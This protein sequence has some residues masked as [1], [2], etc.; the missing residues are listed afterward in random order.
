MKSLYHIHNSTNFFPGCTEGS[1]QA[2][3]T[4]ESSSWRSIN[5]PNHVACRHLPWQ[6]RSPLELPS[7]ANYNDRNQDTNL[8]TELLTYRH[9]ILQITPSILT[10]ASQDHPL[11][12]DSLK[13]R[14]VEVPAWPCSHFPT[15]TSAPFLPKSSAVAPPSPLEG[16]SS[17]CSSISKVF[18]DC[19][20][21]CSFW[22][23]FSST[24]YSLL[25]WGHDRCCISCLQKWSFCTMW[26]SWPCAWYLRVCHLTCTFERGRQAL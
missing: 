6:R 22:W 19:S 25:F 26:V 20:W 17:S 7:I 5:E 15:Y 9:A 1:C 12:T 4:V 14:D 3:I 24:R 8:S 16:S 18:C 13:C 2:Y 21:F 10:T 23:V 11:Y